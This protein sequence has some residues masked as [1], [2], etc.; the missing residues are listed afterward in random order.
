MTPV[1]QTTFGPGRGNCLAACI[2]SL[3]DLPRAE[4]VPELVDPRDDPSGRSWRLQIEDW[5]R[6]RGL[7][8]VSIDAL[9]VPPVI[10]HPT[11]LH[12]M[13]WGR[14]ARAHARHSVIYRDGR[15]V[16]DPHPDRTGLVNVDE[17]AFLV[18]LT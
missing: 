12:Y 5:L 3:L 15:M 6:E 10:V 8:L 16:H 18:R 2:A 11:D 7:G 4:D 14:S 1:D 9:D 17:F 13:A